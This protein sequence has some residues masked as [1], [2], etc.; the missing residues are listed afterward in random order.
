MDE[1]GDLSWDE[2]PQKKRVCKQRGGEVRKEMKRRR[3][4]RKLQGVCGRIKSEAPLII[5]K[6]KR[7]SEREDREEGIGHT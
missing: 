5:A 3:T 4:Y 6:L 7:R 1:G 2:E